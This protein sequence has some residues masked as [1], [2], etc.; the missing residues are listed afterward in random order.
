MCCKRDHYGNHAQCTSQLSMAGKGCGC[1]CGEQGFLSKEEK[2]EL[3]E[4]YKESLK[5]KLEDAEEKLK[6]FNGN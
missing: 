1:G 2:V 4:K 6:E 5:S 3:L